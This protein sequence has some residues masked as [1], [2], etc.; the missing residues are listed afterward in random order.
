MAIRPR[1]R[2]EARMLFKT[3][4]AQ[5][6]L[7]HTTRRQLLQSLAIFGGAVVTSRG[8]IACLGDASEAGDDAEGDIGASSE[9]LVRCTP[10]VI[11]ANHG[12]AVVV[13]A[14]DVTAAVTKTYSIR[15]SSGHDHTITIT[16]A[17]F[18]TLAGGASITV[19]STSGAGHTHD[20][21]VTCTSSSSTD[22]GRADGSATAD[23][24]AS[25]DAQA[26]A[27]ADARADASSSTCPNGASASTIT[28][29]HGHT[30]TVSAADVASGST[31][32]YSIKGSSSHD[33][34][35]TISSAQFAQLRGGSTISVTST[36]VFGH[37]HTVDVL[38]A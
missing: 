8:L 27:H 5:A 26:D 9:E 11:S 30:L 35:V 32:T 22:A 19:R 17:Q 37:T 21:K 3:T 4:D 2:H 28:A 36:N 13:P 7:P 33:H 18:V 14:A 29:N 15:G 12:H 23:S 25:R 20:V 1:S 10:P 16:K 6:P 34:Q 31:K 24:G 38:C